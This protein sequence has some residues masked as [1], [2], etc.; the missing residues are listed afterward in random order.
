MKKIRTYTG[1]S[2]NGIKWIAIFAMIINHIGWMMLKTL[3]TWGFFP[4]F[5]IGHLTMPIMSFFIAEGFRYTRNRKKYALR[6]L[7][8]ALISQL[9]YNYFKL[10]NPLSVEISPTYFNV[11]FTLLL[12]LC[13]LWIARGAW[14]FWTKLPLIILIAL[15]SIL[16]DWPIFGILYVLAFG[17]N[18]G[19][20]K[21]QAL[22]Y[23]LAATVQI[24]VYIPYLWSS[25]GPLIFGTF[26]LFLVLIPLTLYNGKK[27]SPRAPA[28]MANKWM[29]YIIFPTHLII[30]AFLHF[31]M[32]WLK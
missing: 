1:L 12:G 11:L 6:L 9:P 15:A 19:I 24:A 22:W 8:F 17:M 2:A 20:F 10:G 29:F 4:L 23:S 3:G 13:A 14:R 16:C 21:R 7:I 26:G 25:D 5:F 32:G 27:S 30:L 28:W 18:H 31:G